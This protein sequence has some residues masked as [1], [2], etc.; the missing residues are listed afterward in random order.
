MGHPHLSRREALARIPAL[1]GGAA[2]APWGGAAGAARA[3]GVLKGKLLDSA[4]GRPVA[5]K[6]RI[7]DA[8]TGQAFLPESCVRSM[9]KTNSAGVRYFYARGAYEV[10]VPEGRYRI[11]VVRG[12]CHEPQAAELEIGAGARVHDVTLRRL[13][14][15]R[16]AGWYAGNTHTHYNVDIEESVDERMRIVPPAEDVDVS[17]LS[18][19]IRN[20]LPY[21]SNRIPIGRLPDYSRDGTILDMGEECRNNFVSKERPHNL[22]YGHCLFLRIPRLIEPVSTGQLSPGGDAPDYPTLSMLCA[23]AR[24][25]GGVTVWCHNGHGMEAPVAAALGVAD[26]LNIA[27]G[28]PVEYDWYY[29]FLNCGFHL[30]ISTGTDWWEYD[31]NRVFARVEGAFTY[32]SW[33][34]GLRAGRTFVTN[35]PLL[36]LTVNGE[37]PGA[38]LR[39]VKRVRVRARAISRVPFERL[40]IVHDGA[41]VADR[42]ASNGSEALLEWEA[43]VERSGWIAARTGGAT[44]TRT[45]YPVFAHTG[46]VYLR[47]ARPPARRAESA[48]GWA[49]EIESSKVFIRKNYK[50]ASQADQA[51]AL[52]RFEEARRY[53]ASMASQGA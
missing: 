10:A 45:G 22:G 5:A 49:A 30:P 38:S 53:Y 46:P 32:D 40:E 16:A 36:E 3:M 9:P 34:A 28:F 19:L 15:L 18:Y 12:I 11:E 44:R 47:A 42:A 39:S 14:D 31:H 1:A 17:V 26:A 20:R 24:R 7:T 25:L 33:L 50:F 48:R 27:D 21:A 13:T 51:L 6:I 4:T 37:G 41:V 43:P 29:R 52:G 35:G 8:A 2:L 23:Q